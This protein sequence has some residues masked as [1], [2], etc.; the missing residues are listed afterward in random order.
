MVYNSNVNEG[1]ICDAPIYLF[2]NG[3]MK[4]FSQM[5]GC[6]GMSTSCYMY[7]Q[8]HPSDKYTKCLPLSTSAIRSTSKPMSQP[9]IQR[10]SVGSWDDFPSGLG[11]EWDATLQCH[12]NLSHIIFTRWFGFPAVGWPGLCRI[13]LMITNYAACHKF[14]SFFLFYNMLMAI[15]HFSNNLMI[16][17]C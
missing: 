7:C 3:G 14:F 2:I 11:T 15:T 12:G 5:L 4:Y 10:V 13:P 6:E 9:L 17:T 16:A 1:T 8:M